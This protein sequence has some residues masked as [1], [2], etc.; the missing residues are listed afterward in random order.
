MD[1][2]HSTV[3]LGVVTIHGGAFTRILNAD[4]GSQSADTIKLG[5]SAPSF[6]SKGER[7]VQWYPGFTH[8]GCRPLRVVKCCPPNS[9]TEEC[10]RH[11]MTRNRGW[12]FRAAT[13]RP[14]VI[15]KASRLRIR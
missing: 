15:P 13:D 12:C 3:E 8:Q 14:K 4:V 10:C 2:E 9:G 5:F 7:D 11:P 6:G 1:T